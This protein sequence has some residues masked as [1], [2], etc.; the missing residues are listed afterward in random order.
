MFLLPRPTSRLL[1]V[2]PAFAVMTLQGASQ[3][4]ERSQIPDEY[5]WNLADVYPSDEAWR[6]AVQKVKTDVPQLKQFEGKLGTSA[7][8]LAT[9]LDT[10]YG[11]DK[12]LS[13]VYVYASLLR[14]S[15]CSRRWRSSPRSSTRRRPT[16]SPRSCA[17]SPEPSSGS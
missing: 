1:L 12:E 5:K 17:S 3:E 9:A 15:P 2:A 8:T 16:S 14:I 7:A 10:L 6:A 11:L 4:R 13:R